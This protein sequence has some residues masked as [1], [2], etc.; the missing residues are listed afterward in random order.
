MYV[1]LG[2]VY[3]I[4]HHC[5]MINNIKMFNNVCSCCLSSFQC[6]RCEIRSALTVTSLRLKMAPSSLWEVA[7]SVSWTLGPKKSS[8]SSPQ[9]QSSRKWSTAYVKAITILSF[10]T[11][12]KQNLPYCDVYLSH[13]GF[14]NAT[15]A[16]VAKYTNT[17]A[18]LT[19]TKIVYK[20]V[21]VYGEMQLTFC[22]I[23][24]YNI[25]KPVNHGGYQNIF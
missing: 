7:G 21:Q 20:P 15:L 19:V 16:A 1:L 11:V 5:E 3:F 22:S 24:F 4:Y 25:C 17:S 12:W 14:L 18:T 9:T 6:C 13:L 2:R 10:R 23:H 8:T